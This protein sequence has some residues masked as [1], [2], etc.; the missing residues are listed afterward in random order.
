MNAP[1][2][3]ALAI[4]L[5]DVQAGLSLRFTGWIV[6]DSFALLLPGPEV[7]VAWVV[8]RPM[9]RTLVEATLRHGRGLLNIDGCRVGVTGGTKRSAQ[10]P[11]PKTV[12]G[13][14]DRTV[15]ARTGHEDTPIDAGRWPPNILLVHGDVCGAE[16]TLQCP[17]R[18]LDSM[19]GSRRSAG[20][21][22]S[23]KG[24]GAT[25]FEGLKQGVLYADGGAASRYYPTFPTLRHAVEW[26]SRLV[27]VPDRA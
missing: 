23:G 4:V 2:E 27:G 20:Q 11:Y 9:D 16:C 18:M 12:D 17:V 8:R 26:L 15:W 6:R 3:A 22:P 19:A 14:Q 5:G 13:K 21:Y 10:I 24:R 7:L 25:V 1:A